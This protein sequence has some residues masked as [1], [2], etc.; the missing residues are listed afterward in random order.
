MTRDP[1][2]V[3]AL[4]ITGA[5]ALA[6]EIIWS[7]ALVPWVGGTAMA[8]VAT[9]G[10]YMLG[11]FFGSAGASHFVNRIKD[12]RKLFL[13]VEAAAALISILM[14]WGIPL[15]DPIFRVLAQGPL[16]G[17]GLGAGLRGL[18]GGSLLF[19]ATV[20]MGFGFP[21][22]IAAYERQGTGG[23]ATAWV[24]GINTAS[25][26]MGALV[27]GFILV[28]RLGILWGSL[29]VV[30]ADLSVL[31]WVGM[32]PSGM[33]QVETDT[34]RGEE[35]QR[36]VEE[37]GP[38]LEN[39][40]MLLGVF[41]GGFVALGLEVILF[42][43]LG[44]ILGPTA[45]AFTLVLTSYVLGLGLGSLVAGRVIEKGQGAARILFMGSWVF[46][47]IL[48]FVVHQIFDTL[49]VQLAPR[50]SFIGVSMSAALGMKAII[51]IIILLPLTSAFG[52]AY[53]AAVSSAGLANAK[54]AGQLYAALTLGNVTALVVAGIWILP[55]LGLETGLL[56]F[57]V[58][59]LMVP[60]FGL[61]GSGYRPKILF[62]SVA[63][64]FIITLIGLNSMRAWDWRSILSA[65]YLYQNS[66]IGQDR[67]VLFKKSDFGVTVAVAKDRDNLFFSLDGKID[68]G[69]L[70][71]DMRTQS[72]IGVLPACL[73]PDPK[74]ALVIGMG[75]G[76]TTADLLR[77][78]LESV[79]CAELSPAVIESLPYFEKINRNFWLDPRYRLI[80]SDGR[81]VLR[82][83]PKK[84]DLIISEP[85]NV[86]TPGVAH[87]F[88]HEAFLEARNALVQPGGLFVQWLHTYRMDPEAFRLII[89]TFLDV[90]PHASVW[91]PAPK[92]TN[93]FLVG[94][95][96]PLRLSLS[97]IRER[98]AY[99]KVENHMA[100]GS[101]MNALSLLRTHLAET[102]GLREITQNTPVLTDARPR[103]EYLAEGAMVLGDP[104]ALYKTMAGLAVS[105]ADKLVD[106][107]PV[108]LEQLARRAEANRAFLKF[109]I[110]QNIGIGNKR[111][112]DAL[113][114]LARLA[115]KF[116]EDSELKWEAAEQITR[117]G[118]KYLSLQNFEQAENFY[119]IALKIWPNHGMA[120]AHSSAVLAARQNFG[121][122]VEYV[123]RL[124]SRN[125]GIWPMLL[126]SQIFM[127]QGHFEEAIL[128]LDKALE[129]DPVSVHIYGVKGKCLVNLR[130]Y[131]EARAMFHKVLELDPRSS[132]ALGEL[133]KIEDY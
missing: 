22:A 86:W 8:Q 79:D 70:I 37:K 115:N 16:L 101:I 114:S 128:I 50:L 38:R 82:Y 103:L 45:R 102:E 124:E 80:Q 91:G 24:Y 3:F 111:P 62:G 96:E 118:N 71:V 17:G 42:R 122:A 117:L 98:L 34:L 5:S 15:A 123:D 2:L 65:P 58:L 116:P 56:F 4:A 48:V 74:N 44:L 59:A 32:K 77:F 104:I 63:A 78:P 131:E 36:T 69:N 72:L 95:L 81:T 66:D 12:P 13:R 127:I 110:E 84:Y 107:D 92:G 43:I 64:M 109:A 130:R 19:P 49:P 10:V 68:G 60:V 30:A 40:A 21:L 121:K 108:F 41:L 93:I 94:S 51:G 73:H 33:K 26:A 113:A 20:L 11:L 39:A 9:V 126:R 100:P 132:R 18:A 125:S 23:F 28:P 29:V 14:I 99:A 67:Q 52:A 97:K 88:T 85:S 61:V 7:R 133:E 27:G 87:L 57:A 129:R 75:T 105:A 46:A 120:L 106:A 31:I 89:S 55:M 25:A 76:Q 53:A 83:G 54:R 6:L 35:A 90:F 1:R 119:T 112:S 47:G